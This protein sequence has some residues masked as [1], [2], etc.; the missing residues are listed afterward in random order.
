MLV[1]LVPGYINRLAMNSDG[2]PN[3][4]TRCEGLLR[5]TTLK[6]DFRNIDG[7]QKVITMAEI[8]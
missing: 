2:V 4:H 3:T 6:I 1:V 5:K 8:I 7:H